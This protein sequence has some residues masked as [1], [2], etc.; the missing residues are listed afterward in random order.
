M[1]RNIWKSILGHVRPAK[2]GISLCIRTIWSESLLGAFWIAK[3]A[4]FLYADNEDW[5]DCADS[6]AVE[7]SLG[8]YIKRH[9][10]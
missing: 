10:L 5:T 7:S 6:Q 8:A 3:D 2:V 4:K 9:I 1:I